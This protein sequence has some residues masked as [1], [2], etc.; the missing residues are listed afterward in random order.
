M[1][2]L[3]ALALPAAA[4]AVIT[5]GGSAT[6]SNGNATLI[7]DSAHPYGYLNFGDLNGHPLAD[8]TSLSAGVVSGTGWGGGSPRFQVDLSNGKS[9]NVYIGDLPNLTSGSNGPTGNLLAAGTRVDS[10]Q[11]DGPFYGTWSDALAKAGSST[12]AGISLVVDGGWKTPQTFVFNS[13]SING[14]PEDFPTCTT[15]HTSLGDFTAAVNDPGT[16]YTGPLPVS[17]C[18]IGVYFDKPG[19][20]TSA[21]I[22]G[23]T[24][25]GVFA[26]QG[27]QVSVTGS[28][29]HQIGDTPFSGNQH[30][31][32]V[33]YAAGTSGTVSNNLIND[34]QKNGVVATGANTVV[35]VLNNTVTGRGQ[36]DSIAQNGVVMLSGATGLIKGNTISGNF[37][38]PK[39]TVA[40]GLL[41]VDAGGVK[42]QAN[43]FSANEQDLCNVGRGGGNVSA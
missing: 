29:I 8:L 16:G 15:V 26:D 2:M 30:G 28:H 24:D 14:T 40:C 31:R 21:D 23:A 22:S 43:S 4:L 7:S 12:I 38:T 27:A 36:L 37:Y 25:Y 32:A 5:P 19:S 18:Q 10:T 41:F 34:Y 9:I 11:I 6:F 13:V 39:S 1:L 17:G 35:N 42:Q 20:V 3:V 33:F